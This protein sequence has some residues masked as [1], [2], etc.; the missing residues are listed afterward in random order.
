[1]SS[2]GSATTTPQG[3]VNEVDEAVSVAVKAAMAEVASRID[4]ERRKFEAELDEKRKEM[5]TM[6]AAAAIAQVH[7][8][9]Q[10]EIC[11]IKLPP[12]EPKSASTTT[13]GSTASPASTSTPTPTP[14]P[15]PKS[16]PPPSCPGSASPSA[17]T[18]SACDGCA[19]KG[20]CGKSGCGGGAAA[21]LAA[22]TLKGDI[23]FRLQLVE[24]KIVV[25]SGK[26]GVGKSMLACQLAVSLAER[27]FLVGILDIDICG[28]S[29]P[30]MLGVPHTGAFQDSTGIKPIRVNDHLVVMSVSFMMENPNEAIIWRG[31]RKQGLIQVFLKDVDWGVLDYLIIDTPPGTSDEHLSVAQNLAT[32]GIDGAI[33][34]TTPQEVAIHAVRKEIDFC[35]KSGIPIIGLVENMD[36]VMCPMCRAHLPVFSPTTGGGKTLA[37]EQNI[38]FLGA[39]PI[40]P[41]LALSGDTGKPYSATDSP[42][43]PALAKVVDNIVAA[44]NT[45]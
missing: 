30:K 9:R 26:G 39:V 45:H 15:T 8:K 40:D 36:G 41:L 4:A 34:I 18:A 29:V 20:S 10:Q 27:G 42:V 35:R 28:P 3:D 17:G 6:A 31:P 19:Q 16:T 22:Q 21:S 37:T 25:M 5:E 33:I 24:H 32:I 1:M 11:P 44:T 43:K 2:T 23:E 7:A 38:P 14:T 13:G 12:P